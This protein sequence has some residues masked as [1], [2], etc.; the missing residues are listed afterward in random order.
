V[1]D[2]I[3]AVAF[4]Q[5]VPF[6]VGILTRHWAEVQA[7]EWNEYAK[8]VSGNTFLAV[9]A[10]AILGTWQTIIDLIGSRTLIA[11]IVFSVIAI[12]AGYLISSGGRR[13]RTATALIQPGSNAGPAFAAVAIAFNNDPLI[14]G[15]TSAIIFM[16]LVV[17]TLVAGY[18]GK[19]GAEGT[20]SE[21]PVAAQAPA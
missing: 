13:T 9:L 10:L 1:A 14:L 7:L 12:A 6:A 21:E 15:A 16:Q 5:I 20:D 19:D 8:K 3:K 4:L 17:G 2:L 18:M 11:G